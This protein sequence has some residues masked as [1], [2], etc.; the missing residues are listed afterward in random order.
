MLSDFKRICPYCYGDLSNYIDTN[1]LNIKWSII[2][3]FCNRKMYRSNY[4]TYH[5]QGFIIISF[6]LVGILLVIAFLYYIK[7]L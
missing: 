3:P 1:Y 5:K 4:G 7:L 6:I 2:C